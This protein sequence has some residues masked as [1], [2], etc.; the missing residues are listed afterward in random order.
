M[1]ET[2]VMVNKA[3]IHERGETA[4]TH[5]RGETA[6]TIGTAVTDET[7]TTVAKAMMACSKNFR[8]I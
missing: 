7:D 8:Y 3:V 2:A 4:V 1:I 6:E 5:E